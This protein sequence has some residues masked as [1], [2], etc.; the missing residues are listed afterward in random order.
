MTSVIPV[1]PYF[2]LQPFTS[3]GEFRAALLATD[4]RSASMYFLH[5]DLDLQLRLELLIANR[6]LPCY[7]IE[8]VGLNDVRF[9]AVLLREFFITEMAGE[10]FP[11]VKR[12]PEHPEVALALEDLA[13]VKAHEPFQ[14]LGSGCSLPLRLR[15][16]VEGVRGIPDLR[17]NVGMVFFQ[18]VVHHERL[19][20]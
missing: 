6:A 4:D 20:R 10:L 8:S 19:M 7:S 13:A 3:V 5:V 16:S 1:L 18:T 14:L 12:L 9:H 11:M 15:Q 17:F 2:V